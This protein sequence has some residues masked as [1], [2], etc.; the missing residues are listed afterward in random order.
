MKG[1]PN[2]IILLCLFVLLII[3]TGF[4]LIKFTSVDLV[5]NEIIILAFVFT[6]ISSLVL[7]IFLRGQKREPDSQTIH[8]MVSV[9]LK[10]IL[11]LSIAL[12]WFFIAK[13]TAPASV[14]LFFILYLAFTLFN[15]FVILNTL[16]SKSL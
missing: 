14:I 3:I 5:L 7:F 1:L 11:E 2:Y 8:T 4:F 10:F 9:I 15:I 16:K 6:V 13:K 12:T